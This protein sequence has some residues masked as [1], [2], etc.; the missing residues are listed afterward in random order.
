VVGQQG[1]VGAE[2]VLAGALQG[3]Q[4]LPEQRADG[5]AEDQEE[6]QIADDELAGAADE[7]EGIVREELGKGSPG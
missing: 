5:E 6:Q 7:L 4:E 3:G 1:G 2:D